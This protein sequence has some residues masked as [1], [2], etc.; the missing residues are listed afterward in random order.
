MCVTAGSGMLA[1]SAV[2]RDGT[3]RTDVD[4]PPVIVSERRTLPSL[5]ESA[6]RLRLVVGRLTRWLRQHGPAVLTAGQHSALVTVEERGPLRL[7]ALASVEGVS[8]PTMTR[9][10]EGLTVRGLVERQLDANDARCNLIALS[11]A[12]A[13]LLHEMRSSREAILA[14]QLSGLSAAELQRLTDALP[15]LEKIMRVPVDDAGYDRPARR[16]GP[17]A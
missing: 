6:T 17:A 3:V 14:R 15:V 2:E 10:V 4:D 16:D 9:V 12:G 11:D 13:A 5:A 7:T 1:P 8:P